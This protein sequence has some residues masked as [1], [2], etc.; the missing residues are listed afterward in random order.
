VPDFTKRVVKRAAGDLEPGEAVLRSVVA[1]PPGSL[2]RGINE[3]GGNVV[4]G[5]RD[6]RRAK[7]EHAGGTTGLAAAVPPQNVYLTLTD[8]RLLVH[9]MSSMGSPRHL[10]AAFTLDRLARLTL[11]PRRGGGILLVAFVDGTSVDFLV[12][13]SQHP[14]EFLA[15]WEGLGG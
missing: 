8:R 6:G 15:V 4:S 11:E 12:V 3:P 9:T 14:E 10:A 13:Q 2:T 1:Q 5:F 7:Q